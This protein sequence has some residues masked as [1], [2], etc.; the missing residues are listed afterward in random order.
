[1]SVSTKEL[2]TAFFKGLAFAKGLNFGDKNRGMAED[3]WITIHPWGM[4]QSEGDTGEGKGYYRRI[5]IDDETG[6][7]EKGL[8]AG[9][10]IKDLS[11]TLKAKKN[12]EETEKTSKTDN[13]TTSK[14]PKAAEPEKRTKKPEEKTEQTGNVIESP[15]GEI[16]E[17]KKTDLKDFG[18]YLVG[19]K[20]DLYKDLSTEL[21]STDL[22][23]NPLSKTWP[24]D[25]INNIE[26]PNIAAAVYAL[27][28]QVPKKPTSAGWG[29][30]FKR[31][32]W[33][34]DVNRLRDQAAEI[35][36]SGDVSGLMGNTRRM[37][38]L[39]SQ[40]P[41]SS[42]AGVTKVSGGTGFMNPLAA[43]TYKVGGNLVDLRSPEFAAK[44]D[45][46]YITGN[47]FDPQNDYNITEVQTDRG[48]FRAL[49]EIGSNEKDTM[50]ALADIIQKASPETE[51]AK[52]DL[53]KKGYTFNI[54]EDLKTGKYFIAKKGDR[55]YTKLKEF[56]D[57]KDARLFNTSEH[58]VELTET[59]NAIKAAHDVD[60]SKLR[61][62]SNERHG[63]DYRGG[64]A[65][66]PESYDKA[67]GFRGVQFGNWVAQTGELSRQNLMDQA[68]DALK[69]LANTAG[70]TSKDISLDGTLGLAFGARGSG[71]K[72]A[73]LAH[74][75]PGTKVIN[76]TKYGGAGCVAHEWF[77]ALDNYVATKNG[78]GRGEFSTVSP[79][80]LRE[81]EKLFKASDDLRKALSDT[82]FYKA[83][84][85]ADKYRSKDYWST[86]HE[87]AARGFEAYV[88]N[89]M[90]EKG[91]SN[92]FLVNYGESDVWPS[93]SDIKK[94]APIYDNYLKA[95]R[96]TNWNKL[97]ESEE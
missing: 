28:M 87:L 46:A 81:N 48:T 85:K 74:Y 83:S 70:I 65:S 7:I 72:N 12:G 37:Q 36:K 4:S 41:R 77:H 22:L 55:N 17:V 49:S 88:R 24:I 66:T 84:V 10:N 5:F 42:W 21:T 57:V 25:G 29:A 51:K 71:G 33:V 31:D 35:V 47:K 30:D 50:K 93:K 43:V 18:E 6:E 94:L 16:T 38:M 62:R 59:F 56:D 1:M 27:R 15:Q 95:V 86:T 53:K 76:L 60:E 67:F 44:A 96:E 89:K 61:F 52:E 91:E 3:R 32:R 20:K 9:T 90:A 45:T 54:Y 80:H 58:H 19:A 69:D 13:E 39:L 11:K 82:D 64:K 68:Y 26:D 8:G 2:F 79:Y 34:K 97:R 23:K 75:E 92:K 40:L 78:N 63:G 14:Q 73:A